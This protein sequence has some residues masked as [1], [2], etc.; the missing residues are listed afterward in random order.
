MW[1]PIFT[2]VQGGGP[3]GK[4]GCLCYAFAEGIH[5]R[6]NVHHQTGLFHPRPKRNSKKKGLAYM[7]TT[8]LQHQESYVPPG[9]R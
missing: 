2:P 5:T 9:Y 1:L 4:L 3:S 8:L 6:S 7:L